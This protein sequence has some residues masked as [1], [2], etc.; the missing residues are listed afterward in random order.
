MLV[1][2]APSLG[3]VVQHNYDE[4]RS[5][6]KEVFKDISG[7]LLLMTAATWLGHMMFQPEKSCPMFFTTGI[8]GS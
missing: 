7:D 3:T 1:D 5:V 8:T 2:K 4:Y 6:V